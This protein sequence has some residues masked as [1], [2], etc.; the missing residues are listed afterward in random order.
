M[1][2][3]IRF[4]HL[5]FLSSVIFIRVESNY[6]ILAQIIVEMRLIKLSILIIIVITLKSVSLNLLNG[7]CGY[8]GKP[9]QAKLEPDNKL[10]YDEGEEVNYQ[11]THFWSFV[12]TRKCEKGKWS[13]PQPRCGN[14]SLLIYQCCAIEGFVFTLR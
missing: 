11:C 1:S 2:F 5:D 8:P 9:Y 6:S 12:Q 4:F 3:V 14:D 13:G 7:K 10:Q